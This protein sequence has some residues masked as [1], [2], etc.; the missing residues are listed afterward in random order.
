M[1]CS[2]ACLLT[3]L[4]CFCASVLTCSHASVLGMPTCLACL[5]ALVFGVL[6]CLRVYEFSMLACPV[7]LCAHI[8]YM[9]AVLKYGTCLRTC[10]LLWHRLSY[11]LCIWKVNFQKSSYRKNFF[12]FKEVFRTYL[13]IYEAVFCEKEWK[14]INFSLFLQKG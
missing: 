6:T 1:S 7:S 4:V 13:N 12:L 9:H 14:A 10:V 2:Y 8:F 11:F 3:Y 5:R